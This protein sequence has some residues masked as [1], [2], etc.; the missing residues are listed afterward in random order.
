MLP[1]RFRQS[2]LVPEFSDA[3]DLFDRILNRNW[4]RP[5]AEGWL[6]HDVDINEDDNHIVVT[7]ELPGFAK[8]DVDITLEN[9]VLTVRG[10]KKVEH[11]DS[12][13]HLRERHYGKFARSF[14]LP[15]TVDEDKVVASL[16]DGILTITLDKVE[17][18]KPKKITVNGG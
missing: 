8:E 3:F 10:E 1:T 18:A 4:T 5:A 12:E 11:E 16:K 2:A 9:S 15:T 6:R 17:A 13:H 14:E 7:A